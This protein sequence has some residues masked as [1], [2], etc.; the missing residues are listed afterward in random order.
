MDASK[1]IEGAL[2]PRTSVEPSPKKKKRAAAAAAVAIKLAPAVYIQPVTIANN[3]IKVLE[4]LHQL[5]E[6]KDKVNAIEPVEMK[7]LR[8]DE[9]APIP[10]VGDPPRTFRQIYQESFRSS[11]ATTAWAMPVLMAS[12]H[13]DALKRGTTVDTDVMMTVI[14]FMTTSYCHTRHA[15]WRT[16]LLALVSDFET[17]LKLKA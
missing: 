10:A 2:K 3:R 1:A 7:F 17:F 15:P 12:T 5:N 14:N 6:C 11:G 4:L 16:S 13:L 9:L 8:M